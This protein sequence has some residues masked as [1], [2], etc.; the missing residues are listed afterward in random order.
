[1][2][3]KP[4]PDAA[5]KNSLSVP[6]VVAVTLA[7][8]VFVGQGAFNMR[9]KVPPQNFIHSF[10]RLIG[11]KYTGSPAPVF[12]V[13]S[14]PIYFCSF[15]DTKEPLQS[16]IEQGGFPGMS[17]VRGGKN[18]NKPKIEILRIANP[19]EK[20]SVRTISPAWC[21]TELIRYLLA[22]YVACTGSA[23]EILLNTVP[24]METCYV[25]LC[26]MLISLQVR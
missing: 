14:Y 6:S 17:V 15:D 8:Q 7:G 24:G 4:I 25:L 12:A 1:M 9:D 20:P 5:H 3:P 26:G 10:K 22:M 16:Q 23:V 13:C 2:Q 19:G 18:N 21:Q 11:K